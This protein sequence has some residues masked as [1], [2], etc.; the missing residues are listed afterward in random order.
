LILVQICLAVLERLN[1][2]ASLADCQP[3]NARQ[4]SLLILWFCWRIVQL[5]LS[6]AGFRCEGGNGTGAGVKH[7]SRT[8]LQTISLHFMSYFAVVFWHL[9][10]RGV[11]KAG[12]ILL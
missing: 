11:G 8:G 2:A 9:K 12:G 5:G 10:G 7:K 3:V 6:N 1:L 4:T